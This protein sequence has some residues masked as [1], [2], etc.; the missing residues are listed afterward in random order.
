[1][2]AIGIIIFISLNGL[3]QLFILHL[4][5]RILMGHYDVLCRFLSEE[6]ASNLKDI[7][8][9]SYSIV[10]MIV[11]GAAGIW[12]PWLW[13]EPGVALLPGGTVFTYVLALLG[14]LVCNKLFFHSNKLKN[15]VSTK[16]DKNEVNHSLAYIEH[17]KSSIL[18]A[19]GIL[20]GS[21]IIVITAIVY[22]KSNNEDSLLG[23]LALILSWV[24]YFLANVTEV[25]E[26][27]AS[28]AK[29]EQ[30]AKPPFPVLSQENTE[31]S[32]GFFQNG[33]DQ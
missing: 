20:A 5:A 14:S 13:N 9:I 30:E 3:F 2:M 24:L 29:G 8:V 26:K 18:S 32:V 21:F 1:M 6:V 33:D 15:L 16:G 27:T 28:I 19:W 23:I 4:R 12:I 25:A 17:E 11:I 7:K 22:S 10:S 31:F